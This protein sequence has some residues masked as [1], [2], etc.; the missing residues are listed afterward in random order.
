MGVDLSTVLDLASRQAHWTVVR[1]QSGDRAALDRLLRAVQGPL[2]GH[3]LAILRDEDAAKDVLQDTLLLVARKLT[4]LRDP[5]RFRAW[6]FRI[7]T[8]EAVRHAKKSRRWVQADDADFDALHDVRGRTDEPGGTDIATTA[9]AP[10]EPFDA[11][12]VARVPELISTLPPAAQL[13][14]RMHY[15]EEMTLPEIAEALEAP[16]GTIKSRLA[17]GLAGLRRTPEANRRRGP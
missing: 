11:G 2:L 17:Y 8:R 13:V 3:I 15:L 12:L 9:H 4:W 14:V 16:L 7:A 5:R 10:D 6:A 1:A